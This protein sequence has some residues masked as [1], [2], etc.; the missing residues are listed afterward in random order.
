MY[1]RLTNENYSPVCFFQLMFMGPEPIPA[2]Q[3]TRWAPTAQN[4]LPHCRAH[5]HTQPHS[6]RLNNLDTPIHLMCTSWDLG[7]NQSTW[8]T[9][10]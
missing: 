7:G 3:G 4:A 8:R 2:A 10:V 1:E 5:S 9:P 6:L